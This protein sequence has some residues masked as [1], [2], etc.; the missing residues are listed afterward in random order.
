VEE[1]KELAWVA[2]EIGQVHHSRAC[3]AEIRDDDMQRL[4]LTQHHALLVTTPKSEFIY[5]TFAV[6]TM[7]PS[8]HLPVP[9]FSA[10]PPPPSTAHSPSTYLFT[11]LCHVLQVAIVSISCDAYSPVCLLYQLIPPLSSS[12]SSPLYSSSSSST[13]HNFPGSCC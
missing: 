11:L 7:L 13:T 5:L 2:W 8:H 10:G 12:P 3:R 1:R 4:N 9:R 6:A